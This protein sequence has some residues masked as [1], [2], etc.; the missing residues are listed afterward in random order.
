MWL[1]FTV[2]LCI[3]LGRSARGLLDSVHLRWKAAH[4]TARL[5][6]KKPDWQQCERMALDNLSSS[7][8]LLSSLGL[9]LA[10]TIKCLYVTLRGGGCV[11]YREDALAL[12]LQSLEG[13][14]S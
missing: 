12:E 10:R 13:Y 6:F 7:Q 1:T 2:R 11:K 4:V 3:Q 5:A 9:F 14:C 8:F